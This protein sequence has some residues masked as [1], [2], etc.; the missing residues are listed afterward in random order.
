LGQPIYATISDIVVYSPRGLTPKAIR[1][2]ELFRDSIQAKYDER[3]RERARVRTR[4][5]INRDV[6]MDMDMNMNMDLDGEPY[7]GEADADEHGLVRYN[8]FVMDATAEEMASAMP[9]LMIHLPGCEGMP[10]DFL[11]LAL[12]L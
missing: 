6:D 3:R 2:A 12:C 10:S 11:Y 1:L 4:S 7:A 9:H 5:H 8:V